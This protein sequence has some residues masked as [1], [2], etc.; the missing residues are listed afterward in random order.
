MRS[1]LNSRQRGQRGAIFIIMGLSMLVMIAAAGLALDSGRLYIGKTETQNAADACAL[2]ASQE[3]T[4]APNI[5]LTNFPLAEDAG[6]V[7][8]YR[9]NVQLNHASVC[10]APSGFSFSASLNG[11]WVAAG[12]ATADSRYVR[13]IIAE[14]GIAPTFMNVLGFSAQTV[15][16]LATATLAPSQAPCAAIPV[17]L[18][19]TSPTPPYGL[20]PGQW[21]SAT[22]GNGNGPNGGQLTGNFGWIDFSPPA[23]GASELDA[24]LAGTGACT[25]APGAKVGATGA[26]SSLAHAWNTRF[27]IYHPSVP[28]SGATS[29]V[30]DR[31]GY[32]YTG[33]NWPSQSNAVSNF[34]GSRRP[35]N[36]PYGVDVNAGNTLTGL[37]VG[38]PASTVRQAAGLAATGADRRIV[39]VPIIQCAGF[40]GSQTLPVLNWGCALM[41]HPI[42]QQGGPSIVQIEY[43]GLVS[44]AGSPCATVGSVG[45]STSTGPLVPALV[46]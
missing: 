30:P 34:V 10:L 1:R 27:G 31:S 35:A 19:A 24:L 4:G 6:R 23:G 11:P 16:S 25:V 18:C 41:L 8:A 38:P 28:S 20:T 17:A 15:N 26:V 32:A 43:I 21:L 45:N 36:A 9:N 33:V 40:A 37:S 39:P 46:Q 3:L 13:C 2:S 29:P 5:P 42:S 14:S 7:V 22:Y 12:A 44:Q